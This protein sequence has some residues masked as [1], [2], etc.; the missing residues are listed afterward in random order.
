M[1]TALKQNPSN[2]FN[3]KNEAV[4]LIV[5]GA[6]HQYADLS[7]NEL[8]SMRANRAFIPASRHGIETICGA[9]CETGAQ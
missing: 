6:H 7:V 4:N 8:E 5:H 3:L 2:N 9:S 1:K